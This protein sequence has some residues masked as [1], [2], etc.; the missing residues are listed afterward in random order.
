[1]QLGRVEQRAVAEAARAPSQNRSANSSTIAGT[2]G[3]IA[4]GRPSL[5]RY[6]PALILLAITIADAGR[7]ADPDLW[8]HIYFGNAA[9][10][11]RHFIDH[12]PY[13]YSAPGHYWMVHEWLS[14]A[15]MARVYDLG[16]IVGLKLWRFS[17]TA[18]TVVALALAVTESG[19][20]VPIQFSVMIASAFAL[21]PVMQFRPQIFSYALFAILMALLARDNFRGRAPLWTVIPILAAWSN[22]HGAFFIGL[23][24][25]GIYS[26]VRVGQDLVA[27]RGL[28][29]AFGLIAITAGAALAT[30]VNPIG[31]ESWR[32]LI[33]SLRNPM[34]RNII[35]DWRPL[36]AAVAAA[37]HGLH[38]GIMFM[39]L[40]LAIIAALT[41]SAIASPRGGDLALLAIAAVM[42]AAAFTAV[43]N[44]SFVILAAATP[45]ARHMSL[46]MAKARYNRN[47]AVAASGR[48]SGTGQGIV[49]IASLFLLLGKGG[50]LASTL[51]AEED[52]PVGAV[53]FMRAHRLNG[54][55]LS[56]F[57]WGQ[58]L[59]W[60]LAPDSKVFID[61]RYDLVYPPRVVEDYI[62][63]FFGRPGGDHVLDDYP[64]AFVLVP[65]TSGAFRTMLARADWKLIYRD[66]NAVL[67]ARANSRAAL[68]A[69]VPFSAKAPPSNFP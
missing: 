26:A 54:N 60:H 32:T 25:L 5:F 38:S 55:I 44:I 30:L 46:L 20:S 42:A 68:I 48:M 50:L 18:V 61:G 17:M 49:L 52:Y 53:A 28:S 67:F 21:I 23:V 24:A 8:G 4:T 3:C 27:G 43:R 15:V 31:I 34:T 10:H 51:P 33:D 45:L 37:S 29:R 19:A 11:A 65:P 69:G 13:N 14:E 57:E 63:F 36:L 35:A 22:L 59:I 56:D 62:A 64:N 7:Y 9:I 6:G 41:I 58:Y 47:E 39:L 12:D 66:D 40:V 2:P 1:M 16:G